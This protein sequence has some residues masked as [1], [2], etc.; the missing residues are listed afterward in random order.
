M[1]ESAEISHKAEPW[2]LLLILSAAFLFH[3]IHYHLSISQFNSRY[4]TLGGVMFFI[5]LINESYHI[6]YWSPYQKDCISILEKDLRFIKVIQWVYHDVPLPNVVL[7][8]SH[9]FLSLNG[10]RQNN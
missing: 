5:I 2:V 3:T 6:L 8:L 9:F 7:I 10:D 4:V 1:N